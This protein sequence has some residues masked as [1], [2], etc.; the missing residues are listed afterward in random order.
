[1]MRQQQRL[2]RTVIGTDPSIEEDDIDAM[3]EEQ[4]DDMEEI[5]TEQAEEMD[6]TMTDN[7]GTTSNQQQQQQQQQQEVTTSKVTTAIAAGDFEHQF[8]TNT[9]K[10]KISL[11]AT[12]Q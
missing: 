6:V 8:N 5:R 7:V 3:L 9:K 12:L 10:P 4:S 2:R 1:M 11:E